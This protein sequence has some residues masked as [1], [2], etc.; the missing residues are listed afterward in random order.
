MKIHVKERGTATISNPQ[1]GI[2][3]RLLRKSNGHNNNSVQ[4]L[5]MLKIAHTAIYICLLLILNMVLLVQIYKCYDRY[6]QGPTYIETKIVPQRKALF[7]AIT[8]CAVRGGYKS[9]VLKVETLLLLHYF[10]HF[11]LL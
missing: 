2:F 1:K 11:L 9:D 4:Y 7:P 10:K 3:H 6:T 5:N 8:I